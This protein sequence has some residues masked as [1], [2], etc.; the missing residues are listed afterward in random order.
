MA[1]TSTILRRCRTCHF[2]PCRCEDLRVGYTPSQAAKGQWPRVSDALGVHPSQIPE[3][4]EEAKRL[5]THLDFTK[6]GSAI[7]DGPQHQN[8]LL[9]KYRMVDRSREITMPKY[10]TML[11]RSPKPYFRGVPWTD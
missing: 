6:D 1:A 9:K 3:A 7:V 2:T 10:K 11:E 4:I 8:D 5:G